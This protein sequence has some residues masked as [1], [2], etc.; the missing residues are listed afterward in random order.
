VTLTAFVFAIGRLICV[1]VALPT[2]EAW[3]HRAQMLIS[4]NC[5]KYHLEHTAR[6]CDHPFYATGHS[7][8][9][10]EAVDT[11]SMRVGE[12]LVCW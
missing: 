7:V 10:T 8:E 1:Q 9:M 5:S 3:E 6:S 4:T 2:H 11:N 12:V